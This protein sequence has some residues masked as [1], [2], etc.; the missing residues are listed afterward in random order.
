MN[1]NEKIIER[2]EHL[3]LTDTDIVEK[4]NIS[5]DEYY[6]IEAYPD[7]IFTVTNLRELKQLCIALD[8]D[9]FKLFKLSPFF[10]FKKEERNLEIAHNFPRHHLIKK[11]REELK[12]SQEELGELIGFEPIAV[13]HMEQDETYLESWSLE[14]VIILTKALKLPLDSLVKWNPKDE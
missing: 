2:R 4:T 3:G 1:I 10:P 6:D 11:R 9:L 8:L 12:L 7:E 14:L 13:T 5:I